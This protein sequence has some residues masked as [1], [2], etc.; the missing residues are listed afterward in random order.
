MIEAIEGLLATIILIPGFLCLYIPYKTI[1]IKIRL[2][3]FELSLISLIISILIFF[4]TLITYQ[5]LNLVIPETVSDPIWFS[6]IISISKLI[7]NQVFSGLFI[8]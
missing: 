8:T 7:E 5:I 1:A 3:N 2:T 6:N 4:L